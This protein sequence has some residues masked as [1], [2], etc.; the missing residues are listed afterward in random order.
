[1]SFV[2]RFKN[3]FLFLV[4]VAILFCNEGFSQTKKVTL[5][6]KT[7]ISNPV[8]GDLVSECPDT[9]Y[10]MPKIFLCGALASRQ[11]SISFTNVAS[12][13]W[14][15]L[16]ESS[17]A[18]V[19][20][21]NCPNTNTLC[22]WS[23]VGTGSSFTVSDAGQYRIRVIFSDSSKNTFY[24]N[25]YQNGLDIPIIKT[26]IYCGKTGEITIAQLTGY[27]YSLQKSS[28]YQ[29][30]N[31]F[32]ITQEGNYTVYVRRVGAVTTD[33]VFEIPVTIAKHDLAVT[34][35]VTQPIVSGDKG[36]IKLTTANVREQYFYKITQGATL[37]NQV[38][39]VTESEHTFPN[40]NSGTYTWSVKT[41]DCDWKSGQV[42]I[43]SIALFQI[44]KTIQPVSCVPGSVTV[45]VTGGTAPYKYYFNGNATAESSNSI[46]VPVA[47]T[48]S[49]KVVDSNNQSET[50]SVAVPSQPA[51][52]YTIEKVNEN[53]YYPNAWQIKFNVTNTNG[54]GLKY[55]I[56]NGQT[57]T[58]NPL[59][60]NLTAGVY[61]TVVEY[62]FGTVKCTKK[63]DVTIVQPQFGLSAVAGI[64]E[65]I[66]CLPS[67][68]EDKAKVR[69]TNPQGGTA[70]YQYSFDNKLNW[71]DQNFAFKTPGDYVFY[72]KDVNG[73]TSALPKLVIDNIGV[74]E[75]IIKNNTFN[76][77][78]SAT[79]TVEISNST[80]TKFSYKYYLDGVAQTTVAF[81]N[82]PSGNHTLKVEYTPLIFPDYSNLLKEDFGYGPDTTSPGMNSLYCF[83]KQVNPVTCNANKGWGPNINDG[84]YAVTSQIKYPFGTW[85]NV[86]DHTNSSVSQGR[87]LAV[88]VGAIDPKAILYQKTINDVIPNQ[89]INVELYAINLLKIG[90]PGSPPDLKIALVDVTNP[91]NIISF[92]ST[93]AIN[94]TNSWIKYNITLD[95]GNR[96]SL[97]FIIQSNSSQTG[98]ND[99]AIDDISAYQIPKLCTTSKSITFTVPTGKSFSAAVT[100][101]KSISCFGQTDGTITV[102]VQNYDTVK[103]YE[104]SIDNGVSWLSSK[105]SPLIISG[106]KK[107]TYPIK[108]RYDNSGSCLKSLGSF[109]INEPIALQ[110]SASILSPARCGQGAAIE[111]QSTG[112][113]PFYVYELWEKNNTVSPFKSS[114]NSGR[115]DNIP[116]GEYS[117]LVKDANGC[118]NGNSA[119]ISILAPLELKADVVLSKSNLCY[120][121][122]NQ[123]TLVVEVSSGTAPFTFSLNDEDAQK[124][125]I[126]TNVG[127]GDYEITIT[128]SNNCTVKSQRVQIGNPFKVTATLIKAQDCSTHPDASIKVSL[129]GGILPLRYKVIKDGS[130]FSVADTNIP[131][132]DSS[133]NYT[134]PATDSGAYSFIITDANGCFK[135]TNTI[136][137]KPK[138]SPAIIQLNE[139]Q[140]ILCQGDT[141]AA[142]EI[143]V[144]TS[145]GI[146]P[147]T[148]EVKNNTTA[149]SYGNQFSG[150]P[151]GDY[152]VT[153]TD[154]RN[155]SVSNPITIIEP[156]KIQVDYHTVPITCNGFG[157]SKGSIVIDKVTGGKAPFNYLVKG[158]NDFKEKED[159]QD[160]SKSIKFDVIDFGLYEVNVVDANG[161]SFLI[162]DVL[163]ASPPDDLD[164]SVSLPTADCTMGGQA[165]VTIGPNS[166]I[167]TAGPFYFST[168]K[169]MVPSYP[170]GDWTSEDAGG[171]KKAT[172]DHL[173]P[174]VKYT[175]VVYDSSTGCFYYEIADTAIPTNSTLTIGNLVS[176]NIS[177]TGEANGKVSFEISSKYNTPTPISYQIYN[178]LSLVPV[179]NASGTTT[180]PANSTQNVINF[181]ALPFGN[182]FVLITEG[183]SATNSGCSIASTSFTITEAA[184]ELT[185]DATVLKTA[186][187]KEKGT[188]TVQAKDGAAPY[189][190]QV[191]LKN[192]STG[193]SGS[194]GGIPPPPPI[195]SNNWVTTNTFQVD[196]GEYTVYV[197]DKYGCQKDKTRTVIEDSAPKISLDVSDVC[198]NEGLF[199]IKIDTITKGISPHYSS[200]NGSVFERIVGFPIVL[201]NQNS[202][203]ITIAVQDVNG[204][205]DR[206]E[207]TI[208]APLGLTKKGVKQPSCSNN[209]GSIE[210]VSIGGSGNFEYEL[211]GVSST[212]S[213]FSG[214]APG[215]HQL[216]I[217]DTS[218]SCKKEISVNFDATTPITG[219]KLES[220]NV[221]CN[222]GSDGTI[223]ASIATPAT[224]VNDN[225]KYKYSLNGETPQEAT[226][227]SGLKA[228]TYSVEVISNKGCTDRSSIEITAPSVI[229]VSK[230]IVQKF[231]CTT[232]ND[233]Q[234][235][236]I[237]VPA[238]TGG[239]GKYVV[240]E[241]I[242]NGIR[243]QSGPSPK[244]IETEL[245]GGDYAI[246]VYDDKGCMGSTVATIK[247]FV[248]MEK[249]SVIPTAKISCTSAEDIQITVVT[250]GGTPT[251]LRYTLTDINPETGIAEGVYPLQSNN[252]GIFTG[253]SAG[254]YIMTVEN[255]ETGCSLQD[256]YYVNDPNT[257]DIKIDAIEDVS[258]YG[259]NDGTAMITFIDKNSPSRAG[260]FSYEIKNSAGTIVG[261]VTNSNDAGPV[262][263]QGLSTGIYTVKGTLISNPYCS[264]TK[265]FTI[266]EPT[267]E[268]ILK[269][270]HAAISC[271]SGNND[272]SISAV[273]SGG[274]LSYE[275][276]LEKNG[277]V[278]FPWS[279]I[280]DFSNLIQ[281]DYTLRVRD[282]KNCQR[283][284]QIVLNDPLP[285]TFTHELSKNRTQCKNTQDV[286]LTVTNVIGGQ[287]S[288]YQYTLT[289]TGTDPI[290]IGPQK[291][292]KFEGLGAGNYTVTVT[293]PWECTS[294]VTGISI[295][296]PDTLEANLML[297]T[298]LS[299]S[300]QPELELVVSGGTA[301]YTLSEDG[302]VYSS[303][304]FGISQLMNVATGTFHYYI[305]DK[306][307]CTSLSNDI[308]I[309]PLQGLKVSIDETLAK[310]NCKGDATAILTAKAEG[311]TGNYNYS[312]LDDLENTVRPAQPTGVFSNLP[313]GKYKVKVESTS[314]VPAV[315]PTITIVEPLERLVAKYSVTDVLCTGS[316][317]GKI[318]VDISGGTTTIKQAIS[319]NLS[320]FTETSL[321]DNLTIG[322]Y[323]IIVQDALGCYDKKTLAVNEPAF[324]EAKIITSSVV[325]ELCFDD[326]NAQ[327]SI[328]VLGGTLPYS[329]ALDNP[330][331]PFEIGSTTQ[332]QFD[333]TNLK[334]GT[335]KVF[336]QDANKCVIDF[337]VQ[338]NEA[339]KLNPSTIVNYDCVNNSQHNLVTVNLDSSIS[340]FSLVQFALDGG[341]YQP[342]NV[343]SN[344]TPG[345]HFIRVKHN[346]GCVK[347]SPVFNIKKVDPLVLSLKQEGLNEI[348]ALPNGGFGN[349]TFMFNGEPNDANPSYIYYKTQDYLVTVQDAN[350][351]N[352][353]VTQRFDYIDICT[354]N[355]FTP[356][357]DGLNDTWA[358]GC[359][360]NYKNL[361][362]SVLDRYG[363]ELG[364]Y[365]LGESWD[366]KY[367]GVE[368]P[369][370]D[371]WYVLKLNNSKDDREFVGHFTLYR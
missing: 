45:F 341:T 333:F 300:V 58:N 222:D 6:E 130:V 123:A 233:L 29:T 320:Q 68:N 60:Q 200:I 69:I 231:G 102:G 98:G 278:I 46:N 151:A 64:S 56:D 7:T 131:A 289:K 237:E 212:N 312:L 223:K 145:K 118:V 334:G 301:P 171:S 180:I 263:I 293:D 343:F 1:M 344:L 10:Q 224:G 95:P 80:S 235:A 290:V 112:G 20:N 371:Y 262:S 154:S 365:H 203:K 214:I 354:P 55:S 94:S 110:T 146:A 54:Y 350:G 321:F 82:V 310:I 281:G 176:Q 134:I 299:C 149:V 296:E 50:I 53:C 313:A 324:L 85:Y 17:C 96:T 260:A 215:A 362:F 74:P 105:T 232:T 143:T 209:S 328:S 121:A 37:I 229:E 107:G 40:L 125:P 322:N 184:K 111:A 41:A 183:S 77:D 243:I 160:G 219:L 252:T 36:I 113:T 63:E 351:C 331:G 65:L 187:C 302:N 204:C 28:N 355:Y 25:V 57:F 142:L 14:E 297:K 251:D 330:A 48:Y 253:L 97:T 31:V 239:S 196:A 256:V 72:I 346:N 211:D 340:D 265:N 147:F 148:Y 363:R 136:E 138:T 329:V 353:S 185:M 93:G 317:T 359:T 188:I 129:E 210:L 186:N 79:S 18:A 5:A 92:K 304:T 11:I 87:F 249:I 285:I 47:G 99:V 316:N 115:F 76:C 370:G 23:Q 197:K 144:D 195:V 9:G 114:Q 78:G 75:I 175:F 273:A 311:G 190:Y 83:E 13:N 194:S 221:S 241:F 208:Y 357:G 308:V 213:I 119:P 12:V 268:L 66:G 368:L 177:C 245:L 167:T 126:F 70:P 101:T 117:V 303:S 150:L 159:N 261:A 309:A 104:Y 323:E 271:K 255:T 270:S 226:I 206:K 71:V 327:F 163:V 227:F 207:T 356:N 240:Y 267:S 168:Y 35:T 182:Y 89:T 279:E 106:L 338:L 116:P 153:V 230:P 318:K 3:T 225:P 34:P 345:D 250:S 342:T 264:A 275:Y 282:Y 155:C 43:N 369:S 201:T 337:I 367:Q 238:V 120:D 276:Q 162:S 15:K 191:V 38:G 234:Y 244:Y 173:L 178:S 62:S 8:T 257:F 86:K 128:D 286:T 272:G 216:G 332:T 49:I 91:N 326:K 174:G 288:D 292:T 274:W 246:H 30:S 205:A 88:N 33:C 100:A 42:T 366:G 158:V 254:D 103:G 314:C 306:N 164:I 157:V 198:V 108:V 137:I 21:T 335:H 266:S 27:E 193:S 73:C 4:T 192:P 161:C 124:S 179:P 133:F 109:E 84:E 24:F 307:G 39:P 305:K 298:V 169:G 242:K 291:T 247:P 325:Q 220:T 287:G 140:S 156:A 166:K 44:T 284:V 364:N 52:V 269:E 202:G 152:T 181:G 172:L 348:I 199:E 189:L 349:Y 165:I 217:T 280:A 336:V 259:G 295:A 283:S 32:T 315:S 51:P 277:T 236:T 2:N 248:A 352:V 294:T 90:Q 132:T 81:S 59:F 361:T 26:D 122:I 127:P 67:P 19:T 319:P 16:N 347:D 139:I 61:K 339:V 22:S 218:T 135:T 358:P 141:T 258:C 360:I 170:S 228:G